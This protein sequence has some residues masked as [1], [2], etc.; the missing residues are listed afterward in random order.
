MFAARADLDL[1]AA[2]TAAHRGAYGFALRGNTYSGHSRQHR[3]VSRVRAC[4]RVMEAAAGRDA[5]TIRRSREGVGTR[6][7]GDETTPSAWLQ[8]SQ[9]APSLRPLG[10]ISESQIALW[11]AA[12]SEPK[13]KAVRYRHRVAGLG[14]WPRSAE[15]GLGSSPIPLPKP[16][17]IAPNPAVSGEWTPRQDQRET[18]EIR[19][20]PRSGRLACEAERSPTELRALATRSYWL[21]LLRDTRRETAAFRG[22][23]RALASRQRKECAN[24]FHCHRSPRLTASA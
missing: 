3:I 6:V 24:G 1:A 20:S 8:H 2:R 14:R 21:G 9:R 5:A 13:A 19:A 10:T 17:T 4:A 22:R 12:A 11:L 15:V 23:A 18:P 7:R 16:S